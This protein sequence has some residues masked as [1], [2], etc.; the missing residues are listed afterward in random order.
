MKLIP[1]QQYQIYKNL[2]WKI[3]K[4]AHIPLIHGNDGNKLSKR[5][6]AIDIIEFRNNGF[7]PEAILN[8][9]LKLGISDIRKEFF[10]INEFEESFNL[11]HLII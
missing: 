10:T 1:F 6:G 8:Y 4:F 9:L 5:H 11:L 3:P 7:L 2:N